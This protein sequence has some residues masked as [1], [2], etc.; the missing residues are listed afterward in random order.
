MT[1]MCLECMKE[2]GIRNIMKG[3]VIYLDPKNLIRKVI[4]RCGRGHF[5]MVKESGK[6]SDVKYRYHE[7]DK[8]IKTIED[9]LK[10][11]KEKEYT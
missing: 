1:V 3:E 7:I 9:F 2:L 6:N 4:Y 10:Y 11:I 8:G 5:V